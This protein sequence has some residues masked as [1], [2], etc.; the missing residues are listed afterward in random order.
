MS[1][2]TELTELCEEK[3]ERS[4]VDIQ[5]VEELCELSVIR[6]ELQYLY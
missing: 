3:I 5:V 2:E 1:G 4:E 6:V